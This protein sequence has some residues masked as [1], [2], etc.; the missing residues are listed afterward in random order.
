MDNSSDAA[1]NAAASMLG[2]GAF[3]GIVIYFVVLLAIIAFVIWMFWRIFT[4]AG[5][6]GALAL[7]NLVPG[8][9]NLICILILAFSVWPVENELAAYR[10][11]GSPTLFPP[12]TPPIPPAGNPPLAN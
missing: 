12:V 5:M 9:G 6:N 11:G 4:K 7:L 10:G 3:I 1:S 8:V 2:V